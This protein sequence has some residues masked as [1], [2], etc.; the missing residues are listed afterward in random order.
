MGGRLHLGRSIFDNVY[1][2]AR[3]ISSYNII[4]EIITPDML[5]NPIWS[6]VLNVLLVNA[7]S[8]LIHIDQLLLS[9]DIIN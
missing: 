5:K 3:R 2:L 7:I 4:S 8:M 1:N 6:D 9:I